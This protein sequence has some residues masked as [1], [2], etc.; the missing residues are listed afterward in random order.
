MADLPDGQLA[1]AEQYLQVK[2]DATAAGYGWYLDL[3]PLEDSEFD[4]P[5]RG[6]ERQ[7]TEYS[8]AFGQMDLLTVV[9]RQLGRVVGGEKLR[10]ESPK[11]W[12]LQNTLSPGHST[13]RRCLKKNQQG[14]AAY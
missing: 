4:I 12:L 3:S 11:G 14:R 9:M 8:S 10:L 13:E 7:A 5:V 2:I 1:S 6:K